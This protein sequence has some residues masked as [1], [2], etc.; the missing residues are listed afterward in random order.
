MGFVFPGFS[1]NHLKQWFSKY[2]PE[3]AASASPGKLPEMQMMGSHPVP[4]VSN[5]GEGAQG[6]VLPRGPD[7]L[8]T[9]AAVNNH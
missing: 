9:T 8:L 3:P 5:S 1:S 4:L 7:G 6:A 2:G